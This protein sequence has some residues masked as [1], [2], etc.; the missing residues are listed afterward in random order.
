[1]KNFK[2]EC[3]CY[4]NSIGFKV[5]YKYLTLYKA[6]SGKIISK[7]TLDDSVIKALKEIKEKYEFYDTRRTYYV[8]DIAY[9]IA[10]NERLNERIKEYSSMPVYNGNKFTYK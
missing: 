8:I 5:G 6:S 2:M 1:M 10:E 4:Y 3:G 9:D 7:I